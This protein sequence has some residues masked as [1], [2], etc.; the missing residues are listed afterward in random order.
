MA[1][2][3]ASARTARQ[4]FSAGN[5]EV[6][7]SSYRVAITK[8]SELIKSNQNNHQLRNKYVEVNML[9]KKIKN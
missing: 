2:Y 8:L 6:A 1:N 5:Y 7:I 4:Q 9:F 3:E